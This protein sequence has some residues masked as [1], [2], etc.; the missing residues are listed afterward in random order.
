MQGGALIECR[1]GE[2][3]VLDDC[4]VAAE[5]PTDSQFGEASLR[6][7]QQRAL[8]AKLPSDTPLR[9]GDKVRLIVPFKIRR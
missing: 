8:M 7:A 9:P 6:M 3:G 5:A 1:L 4:V 2:G